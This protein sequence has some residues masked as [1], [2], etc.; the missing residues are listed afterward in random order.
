VSEAP[1]LL[2]LQRGVHGGARLPSPNVRRETR[3][4]EVRLVEFSPFPRAS[5]AQGREVG[6]TRDLST[7]GMCL[8]VEQAH[9]VGSLLRLT[10]RSIDGR[11]TL[12]S[13]ARVAWCR[14][15]EGAGFAIGVALLPDPARIRPVRPKAAPA[16]PGGRGR[17]RLRLA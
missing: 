17:A 2:P 7:S 3:T 12:E 4:A 15:R 13:I 1:I 14:P 16:A 10:L 8:E 5:A 11:P 9:R 6:F